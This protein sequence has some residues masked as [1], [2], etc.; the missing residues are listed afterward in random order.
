MCWLATVCQT[1]S[2][3]F[4]QQKKNSTVLR[5]RTSSP[6]SNSLQ[7][8]TLT[9]QGIS[10][11]QTQ[12]ARLNC[13]RK[14]TM[15]HTAYKVKSLPICWI[16]LGVHQQVRFFQYWTWVNRMADVLRR[17]IRATSR[18]WLPNSWVNRK[19][20]F[21]C[22]SWPGFSTDLCLVFL[23]IWLKTGTGPVLENPGSSEK[24][25]VMGPSWHSH[26]LQL[27]LLSLG[28]ELT[29]E[30]SLFGSVSINHT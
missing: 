26:W 21:P 13:V 5:H 9:A 17:K 14:E 19:E 10:F 23:S 6:I 27:F 29:G 25:P 12:L 4:L 8:Y 24:L 30:E 3:N 1:Q 16:S 11:C 18:R 7:F 28:P 22:F 15:T 2:S 20:I